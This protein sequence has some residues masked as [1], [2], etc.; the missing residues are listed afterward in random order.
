MIG[1][2]TLIVNGR[3][4]TVRMD[5]RLNSTGKHGRRCQRHLY[6][7]INVMEANYKKQYY[8]ITSSDRY[9][10]PVRSAVKSNLTA[11][12]DQNLSNHAP[13]VLAFTTELGNLFQMFTTR[14][15]KKMFS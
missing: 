3:T 13:T 14:A 2:P 5:T 11:W 4:T 8:F 15:E 10:I 7:R 6:I 9:P 12:C 1:M